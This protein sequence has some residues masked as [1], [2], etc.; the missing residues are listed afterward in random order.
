MGAHRTGKS[1]LAKLY[2]EKHGIP[3]IE[4]PV[5]AIFKALG[6]DP[7]GT[8]NFSTRLTIQEAILD[9]LDRIYGEVG[10]T[11]AITDRT[12][13]DMLGY[14]IAEAIGNTVQPADQERFAKYV[15]RCIEVTNKRF[16]VLVLVQPGVPIV[17]AEG[18][19]AP[20]AAYIEHLNSLMLGLSVD[21]RIKVAHFYISRYTTNLQ[22]RLAALES[23]AGRAEQAALRSATDHRLTGGKVH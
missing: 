1:T 20:N 18:K 14:T 22:E 3:F 16:S 13:V 4:T 15:E 9:R 5:S 17:D 12:P 10:P 21:Q 6:Y 7:A 19:A 8:F 11:E 23:A 2:A